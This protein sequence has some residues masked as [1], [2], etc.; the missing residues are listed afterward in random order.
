MKQSHWFLLAFIFVQTMSHEAAIPYFGHVRDV[1]IASPGRQNYVVVDQSVWRYSQPDLADVRLYDGQT[2]VPYV[3]K[4]RRGG[5]SS[6]EQ[7][8]KLLNLG[9]VA[10]R[11]E[12]DI[13][14]GDLPEYDRVRLRLDAKNFIATAEAEGR[15]DLH[16]SPG[17][18]LGSSTLYDFTR[19][20]LGSNFVLK[21]P[22]ANFHYLHIR[23]APGI[24]PAQVKGAVLFNLQEEKAA[25]SNAG[26]CQ[27]ANRAPSKNT[28]FSCEDANATPV[29]RIEFQIAAA[30][31]NF[32]RSVTATDAKGNE[33]ASGEISR[34]RMLRAG[35]SVVSESLAFDLP[36]TR[37]KQLT[38]TIENG[39]DAPLPVETVLPLS[40]ERRLYFDPAGK[41][42]V[43]V[44]YGDEKLG[45][46]SYDYA[47]FF[48]ED[49][50]AVEAKLGAD[51][52]NPAYTGRPDDRPWSEQH[53]GVLWAAMVLAVAVLAGLALRGFKTGPGAGKGSA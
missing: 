36:G 30:A 12:F 19:E 51:M 21:L 53:K 50:A 13:D 1:A 49:P 7:E 37:E 31:V 39:D 22:T 24:K 14:V 52:P 27:P 28:I 9:S 48:Q 18:K 43:K 40:I 5:V 20:D 26:A 38:I 32:R 42:A 15:N 46:P 45:E 33:L 11:T 44:Y 16:Q 23:L 41:T 8:A 29:D 25:W 10:G 3:L 4:Q 35:Q 2:Q 6:V 47:K 34:I 17:T